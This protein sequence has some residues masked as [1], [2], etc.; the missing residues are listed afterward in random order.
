[1]PCRAC[2]L[3][4][5]QDLRP[6]GDVQR[7]RRLVGDDQRRLERERHGDHHALTL[8]AGDLVR[9]ARKNALRLGQTHVCEHLDD[10]FFAH[11]WAQL[12]VNLDDLIGLA[13]DGHQRVQRDHRLLEDHGDAT[14]AHGTDVL[15]RQRQHVLP[16]KHHA[17]QGDANMRLGQ[18]AKDRLGHDGLAGAG[19]ADHAQDF[20]AHDLERDG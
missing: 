14:T 15:G 4:Q 1:M 7:R 3:E 11:S 10:A 13:A 20:P 16:L 18:Q 8:A 19:L 5:P 9:V 12:G 2:S 17:A 6:G